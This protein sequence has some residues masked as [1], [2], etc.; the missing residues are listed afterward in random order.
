MVDELPL[1]FKWSGKSDFLKNGKSSV[2]GRFKLAKSSL[3]SLNINV[4]SEII[5]GVADAFFTIT[6]AKDQSPKLVITSDLKGLE[7]KV[8][9]LSWHKEKKE[10][11]KLVLNTVVEDNQNDIYF[12]LSTER[13]TTSAKIKFGSNGVFERLILD[14]LEVDG[15]L[16]SSVEVLGG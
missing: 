11:G 1:Q 7:I 6:L 10:K 3:K 13:L 16:L 5:E 9:T 15:T 12:S 2:S 14:N 8:D 4:P